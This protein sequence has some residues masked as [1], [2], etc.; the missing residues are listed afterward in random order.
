[1]TCEAK[2]STNL[3]IEVISFDQKKLRTI[4]RL[5]LIHSIRF[6]APGPAEGRT[7]RQR[8][9]RSKNGPSAIAK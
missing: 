8:G 5:I 3:K 6:G 1:M 9:Y 2:S 4:R 7:V